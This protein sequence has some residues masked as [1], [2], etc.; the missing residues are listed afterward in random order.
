MAIKVSEALAPSGDDLQR[1]DL[2]E[3][4]ID[5]ELHGYVEGTTYITLNGMAT[6]LRGAHVTP[7]QLAEI[8][9][10]Y[11][12]WHVD[13]F[14][15]RDGCSL[16][17]VS[18]LLAPTQQKAA[19]PEPVLAFDR[20]RL[21]GQLAWAVRVRF[22][23]TIVY[24]PEANTAIAKLIAEGLGIAGVPTTLFLEALPTGGTFTDAAAIA[25]SGDRYVIVIGEEAQKCPWFDIIVNAAISNCRRTGNPPLVVCIDD[26]FA[27][28]RNPSIRH[29]RMFNP[30]DLRSTT[31]STL[32]RT[33]VNLA[34][35]L[36][37][38]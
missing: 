7:P 22:P 33:L 17:F 28:T 6:F 27:S 23:R 34:K 11:S 31:T 30:A 10:R 26:T 1:V 14:Y 5:G 19:E 15:S 21:Q 13:V 29:L 24:A 8:R 3:G 16:T 9:R 35:A 36:R 37:P 12:D 38:T 18:K 4:Y 25:E 2:L 20:P 32:E